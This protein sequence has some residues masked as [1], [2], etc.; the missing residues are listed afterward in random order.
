MEDRPLGYLERVETAI[1]RALAA[2]E[3][4]DP[5]GETAPRAPP[6]PNPSRE[7]EGRR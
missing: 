3:R 4:T 6:S 7:R 2:A 1:A 5:A